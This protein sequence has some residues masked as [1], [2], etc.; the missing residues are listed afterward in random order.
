MTNYL[1]YAVSKCKSLKRREDR[2][3][4]ST[5][6]IMIN[7]ANFMI[8]SDARDNFIL[9]LENMSSLFQQLFEKE[10]HGM[11]IGYEKR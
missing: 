9:K 11:I 7:R 2:G 6:S 8:G 5:K 1:S 4:H 3:F 10:P